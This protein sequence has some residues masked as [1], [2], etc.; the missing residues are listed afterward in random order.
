MRFIDGELGDVP[1]KRALQKRI[2]HQPLRCYIK[3]SILAAMQAA[4]TRLC[5]FPI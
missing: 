3:H 2:Q 4:P 5:L 1:V